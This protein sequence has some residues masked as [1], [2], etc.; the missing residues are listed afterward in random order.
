[1]FAYMEACHFA[2]SSEPMNQLQVT[3]KSFQKTQREVDLNQ[4][5]QVLF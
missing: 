1:M 5:I 2:P 3:E 4:T